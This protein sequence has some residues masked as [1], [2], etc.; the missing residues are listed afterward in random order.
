MVGKKM[1]QLL[2]NLLG[3]HEYLSLEPLESMYKAKGGNT[4]L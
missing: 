4:I 3:N 2:K 1:A